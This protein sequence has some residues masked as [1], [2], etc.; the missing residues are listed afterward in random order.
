M[1][2]IEAD[3]P[4]SY[5]DEEHIK[6]GEEIITCT[7]P[8]LHVSSTGEIKNFRLLKEYKWDPINQLYMIAGLVGH[9][10]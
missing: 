9:R 7:G 4:L 6:V 3:L 2:L 1:K 8:R 10:K 5:H